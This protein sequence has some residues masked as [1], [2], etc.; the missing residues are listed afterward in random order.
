[1]APLLPFANSILNL[2][3]ARLQMEWAEP[4]AA[5][6]EL[7]RIRTTI[8][9]AHRSVDHDHC[10]VNGAPIQVWKQSVANRAAE[11]IESLQGVLQDWYTFYNGFDPMF[12]WWAESPFLAVSEALGNYRSSIVEA[13]CE[14]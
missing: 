1:M 8:E 11:A 5:A 3:E 2:E 12:T 4:E 7:N 6:V 10:G 14:A 13:A 9:S